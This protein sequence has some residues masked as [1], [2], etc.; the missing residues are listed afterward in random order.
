MPLTR[1]FGCSP[2][3]YINKEQHPI[4]KGKVTFKTGEKAVRV[5]YYGD[6]QNNAYCDNSGVVYIEGISY[7]VDFMK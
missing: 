3:Y 7:N 4:I 6:Q 5:I 2:D 1:N